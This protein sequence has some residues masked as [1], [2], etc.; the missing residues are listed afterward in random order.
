MLF[1]V[2]ALLYL[3]EC[4]RL[5]PSMAWM[6]AGAAKSRWGVIRPWS[7]LKIGGGSPL[8]LSA[9]PPMNAHTVALPWLFVPE[10]EGLRVRLADDMHTL[11]AWETL[12]PRA[13]EATLHLDGATQVRL[14]GAALAK[15]W[16]LR[17]AEWRAMTPE[18]R[19]AAFLKHARVSLDTAAAEKTATQAA[20]RTRHLRLLATNLFVWCFGVISVVYHRF[21]DG[22]MVLAAGGVLLLLQWVQSWLFLRV[23]RADK[24]L[25]PHRRW[26][27]LGIAFLPQLSMRA[28][29]AVS[30][31]EKKE[32][33]HP[34]AWRPLLSEEKDWLPMARQF[35]REARYVPGWSHGAPLPVEAEALQN[36]FRHEGVAETAYDPAPTATLPTCP[37][38]GAEFQASMTVCK[39]CGGVELRQPVA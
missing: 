39:D 4:L 18:K 6:A 3:F 19:R 33:P 8:L 5:M 29:D 32:P 20:Q 34:L 37:R 28:A 30:L 24:A 12:N 14:T 7:R 15:A 22:P 26:R 13:E 25:Y 31:A 21:G 16:A 38:C 35:W 2:F 9:L 11:L 10:A 1:A 17:L 23:T 27:A 36:F